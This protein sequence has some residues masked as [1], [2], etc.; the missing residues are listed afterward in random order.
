MPSSLSI[1]EAAQMLGITDQAVHKRIRSGTLRATKV[2]KRWVVDSESVAE[3]LVS[4]PRVGRPWSGRS[5]M[6]MNGPYEVM[7]LT[8]RQEDDAFKPRAVLD[9]ARAP[10]GTISR[11]GRGKPEGLR[12]WWQHRSIPESRAGLDAK[13]EKLGLTNPMHIPF[14][15]LGLSLSDQYWIRPLEED[16]RW[17]DLN[18]FHNPFGDEGETWDEW[19]SDVGL[20]SPDN[21]SEGALP[22]RWVCCG[23][24]RILLKGHVPWT[25]QQAYNEVVATLLH[26]KLLGAD[27]F[28]P[29]TVMRTEH[30]GVV[31]CCKCFIQPNEEYVPFSLVIDSEGKRSGE[32]VYDT[33]MR[34]CGNL[35]ISH[36]R[37]ERF[38]S[39]MIVCDSIMA[40]TDRHLRNFGLIRN[41]DDLDWRFAPLF[42]TG[43]SLWY[44]KDEDAIAR[45][46][47]DFVSRPFHAVPIRQ[48]L[49]VSDT[50]WFDPSALRDFPD[51][52]CEIL[53]ESDLARWRLDYLREGIRERIEAVTSICA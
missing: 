6:L 16:L 53:A 21:T 20:S 17:E 48:L 1:H 51:A 23:N 44:D 7:E 5:Y 24:D 37:T 27:D 13:L 50:E 3:A 41:I 8:Y 28:V 14:R 11:N 49:Y 18:Y 26:S 45:G 31:S 34:L 2:N 10:L 22:K 12:A 33:V 4:S 46:D 39:K 40:N 19:L 47:H 15:N 9:A 52:A 32:T 29:Y 42:D 38:L 36:Q 35:G 25:D 30:L 43:N